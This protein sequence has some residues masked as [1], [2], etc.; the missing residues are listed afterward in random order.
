MSNATIPTAA[1][2]SAADVRRWAADPMAFFQDVRFVPDGPAFGSI[3]ADFQREFLEVVSPCLLSVA[4][5]QMPPRRGIWWEGVKG[6]SKDG[7]CSL[8]LLWL[9]TFSPRPITAE[10]AADDQQQANE[11]KRSVAEWLH[12]NPGLPPGLK[13]SPTRSSTPQPAVWPTC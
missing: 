6:C 2:V 5:R 10:L 3:M 8:A 11:L 1:A 12:A 13:F 7:L 9:L 4:R